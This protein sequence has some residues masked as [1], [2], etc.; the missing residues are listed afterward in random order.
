MKLLP[1]QRKERDNPTFVSKSHCV[2]L[3]STKLTQNSYIN[4]KF[5][6]WMYKLSSINY[7]CTC[8]CAFCVY[9][10]LLHNILY[11]WHSFLNRMCYFKLYKTEQLCKY[12]ICTGNVQTMKYKLLLDMCIYIDSQ[13]PRYT[14][15]SPAEATSIN[16]TLI[17]VLR[18]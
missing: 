12:K 1:Y 4:I 18:T 10:I 8:A 9:I 3:N 6:S 5:A 13:R 2:I 16:V 11:I 7:S 17:H 15:L 14:D